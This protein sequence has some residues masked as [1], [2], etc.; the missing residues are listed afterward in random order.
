M[1]DLGQG[2]PMGPLEADSIDALRTVMADLERSSREQIEVDIL[3]TSIT[4]C[5]RPEILMEVS[6][7]IDRRAELFGRYWM[8]SPLGGESPKA[9]ALRS[10]LHDAQMGW[11]G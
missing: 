10:V 11:L 7:E 8:A 6:A 4:A 2:E 9:Q 3:H 1:S 5:V